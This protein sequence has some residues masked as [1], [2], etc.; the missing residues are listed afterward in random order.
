MKT[1][2]SVYVTLDCEESREALNF[3]DEK[4]VPF[5]AVVMDKNPEFHQMILKDM[6]LAKTPIIIEQLENSSIKII[7]GLSNLK[8]YLSEQKG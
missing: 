6:N 4:N 5:M 2:F 8:Q 1:Y 3:L 7:G